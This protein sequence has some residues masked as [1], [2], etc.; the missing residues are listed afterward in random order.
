MYWNGQRVDSGGVA[1][2]HVDAEVNASHSGDYVSV[3]CI[4][5][6]VELWLAVTRKH[7]Y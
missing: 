5:T 4:G 3:N 2:P 7:F 1:T 6:C